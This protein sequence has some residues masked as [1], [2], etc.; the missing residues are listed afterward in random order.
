[1]KAL[2]TATFDPGELSRLARKMDVVHEDWRKTHKVY[3]SGE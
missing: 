1:M 3:F 2:I